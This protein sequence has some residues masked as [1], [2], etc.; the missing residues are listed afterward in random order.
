[1]KKLLLSLLF[2]VS[3]FPAFAG[4]RVIINPEQ[5]GDLKI[6]VNDNGTVTDVVT[7]DGATSRMGVGTST[8]SYLFEAQSS[9][10]GDWVARIFNT[11]ATGF[12][13][14]VTTAAATSSQEVFKIRTNTSTDSF[15]TKGDGK[16]EL[17]VRSDASC[18]VGNVCSGTFTSADTNNVNM[19]A[20]T[21]NIGQ[22]IRVGN[23]VTYSFSVSVDP[24]TASSLASFRV[25]LPQT[26]GNFTAQREAVGSCIEDSATNSAWRIQAVV[27]AATANVEIS[28]V[29]RNTSYTIYCHLT[30][31]RL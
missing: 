12:G 17:S 30:Y 19:D 27:G 8:P 18:G 23:V 24:T 11:S 22:F 7:F 13:L 5:D 15:I 14:Q 28:S 3:S 16:T 20:V 31:L 1:M 29:P 2:A 25:D 6:K 26:P 21:A 10:P 9:I 4:D